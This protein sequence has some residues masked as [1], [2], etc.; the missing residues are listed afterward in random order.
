MSSGKSN[1]ENMQHFNWNF[2]R[3]H[4]QLN[5]DKLTT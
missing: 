4:T 3:E 5:G 2:L 1:S